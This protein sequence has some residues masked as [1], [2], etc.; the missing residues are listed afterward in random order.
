MDEI[1][2]L[3]VIQ[4]NET[5]SYPIATKPPLKKIKIGQVQFNV[6][7]DQ[8]HYLP[9]AAGMLQ[10]YAKKHLAFPDH[11]EFIETFHR[12][13]KNKAELEE[14]AEILSECDLV[15]YGN[16]VWNEQHI[17]ALSRKVKDR[18]PN[19][20]NVFGGP[21]VPD[22]KKQ[23][24]YQRTAEL[25]EAE[26]TRERMNFTPDYHRLNPHIDI[27][28]HGEGERAFHYVLEQMAIDGCHD[29]SRIPSASYI[30]RNGR[31]HYNNKIERMNDNELA[32]APSP[33]TTGVFDQLM[34]SD[35]GIF[36]IKMYETDRGCP[37]TCR[38]CDWGGA[39][40][41]K[42]SLFPLEQIYAD[43]M[44]SGQHKIP[45][46]FLCNANFGI[47]KRDIQIAEFFAECRARYGCPES[48]STQNAKNPK[49]HTIQALKVL[50][51]AGLNKAA[52]MSQQSMNP[53]TL[54]AVGRDNMKMD[55]YLE[56][57]NMA[58][59]EDI[60]TMTDYIIPLPLE[61]YETVLDGIS[62][63]IRNGQHNRIQS[64]NLSVLRNTEMGDPEYQR[65]Y[66]YE[67]VKARIINLHGK[68]QTFETGIDEF[69]D[70]VVG[71]STMPG[72]LWLRTRALFWATDL[73]YFNKLLQ[74]PLIIL[75]KEYGLDYAEAL[76]VLSEDFEKYGNFPVLRSIRN[77]F[78]KTAEDMRAGGEEFIYSPEYLNIYWPPGE[79]AL[80][81]LCRE[82]MLEAFYQETEEVLSQHLS[83]K[84]I[85]IS[86]TV[87]REAILLNKSLLK[88]PFQTEN[89]T[90]SLSHNMLEVYKSVRI[91]EPIP[92][93]NGPHIYHFDR[94]TKTDSAST[95][96]R[97]D[98]WEEWYR[99]MV[100]WCNRN[101]AYLYGN[102]NPVPDLE[103][104]H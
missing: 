21:Q 12:F 82:G 41:D 64:N 3:K 28:I 66:G 94:T 2:M 89:L 5:S 6:S 15:G 26:K 78:I 83:N 104:H 10:A 61:T 62:T 63:L 30:D 97:W 72:P 93:Q 70:L 40:E 17:L 38:Y 34:A 79:Y 90:L 44:W 50:Q 69:Q 32:K 55:E 95:N 75:Y 87:L 22:S 4:P 33:F 71:T 80:I 100:W 1:K 65:K 42:I 53:P 102:R 45:Y 47:K 60:D 31:F 77:L 19:V 29:K 74:I 54:A 14:M 51:R 8:Q 20:I 58:A 59:K 91:G 84:Q 13:P 16:S 52:V 103:G 27:C 96:C 7:F 49:K 9:L 67:I 76:R 36:W 35:P 48:V 56:M 23:F 43:I 98:S 57:Q 11:Y 86:L 37:Y 92:L 46:V 68:K 25:T 18:N 73:F 85:E 99:K 88:I 39:T 24:R 81:K 101:G